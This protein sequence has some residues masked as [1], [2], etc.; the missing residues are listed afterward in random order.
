MVLTETV[1]SIVDFCRGCWIRILA[2]PTP[3]RDASGLLTYYL[4]GVSKGT[5][6]NI[7][8]FNMS[9]SGKLNIG[10]DGSAFNRFMQGYLAGFRI[11]PAAMYSGG[12]IPPLL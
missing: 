8:G 5:D 3:I 11:T 9:V 1:F 7:G 2:A 4:D 6:T 10:Y 12:F